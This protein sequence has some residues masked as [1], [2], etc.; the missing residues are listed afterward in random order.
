MKLNIKKMIIAG[1]LSLAL[2]GFVGCESENDIDPDEAFNGD[3]IEEEEED[4]DD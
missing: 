3:P 4:F 2:L 1:V